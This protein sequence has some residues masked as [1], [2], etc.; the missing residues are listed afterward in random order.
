MKRILGVL[1]GKDKERNRIAKEIHD[2]VGGKLASL[3]LQLVQINSK[4]KNSKIEI[5]VDYLSE[6]FQELRIISHDLS[7][8][9]IKNSTLSFL[10]FELLEHYK[11][12]NEF[13][14]EMI[15]Y[16]ANSLNNLSFEVKHN[17]YR[18]IQELL[19]NISKHAKASAVLVSFT[20]HE[21]FLNIIV[22]DNGVGFSDKE[23]TGIGLKNIEER[24]FSI[25]GSLA[26]ETTKNEGTTLIIEIQNQKND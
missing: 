15:V 7:N 17:V 25:N 2:G 23:I 21:D 12:L 22:E 19:S 6:V 24:L 20:Q 26:I 1:E 3:K 16:P 5:I 4:M 18:I 14:F 8:H 13:E 10:I 11:K 9:Y